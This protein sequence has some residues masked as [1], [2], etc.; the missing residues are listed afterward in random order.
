MEPVSRKKRKVDVPTE[1]TVALAMRRAGVG[2]TVTSLTDVTVFGIGATTVLPS[3][4]SYSLFTMAGILS[5]Y[6]LQSTLFVACLA[7]DQR[8]IRGRRDGTCCWVVHGE[9]WRPW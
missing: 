6:L 5:V 2:I 4:R 7:L 9:D 1:E 3:L 8:R